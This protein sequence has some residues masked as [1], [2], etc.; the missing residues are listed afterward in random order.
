MRN[1]FNNPK[2]FFI[3]IFIN[4]IAILI[5]FFLAMTIATILG[6]T[7]DWGALSSGLLVAIFETISR[8]VYSNKKKLIIN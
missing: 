5:G 4:I 1:N 7:G 8:I 6:Q 3:P 2:L